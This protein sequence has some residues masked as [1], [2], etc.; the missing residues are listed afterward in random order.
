[1]KSK[2]T[3]KPERE[4]EDDDVD[5]ESGGPSIASAKKSKITIIAASSVL[6]TVVLYF[7]FFKGDAKK[8]ELVEV[9]PPKPAAISQSED[10]KS[11]FE[12]DVKEK[13][14]EDR[15]VVAKPLVPEVP[16]LPEL[17]QGSVSQDLL[18]LPPEEIPAAIPAAPIAITDPSNPATLPQNQKPAEQ[19]LPA[20]P[21]VAEPP[22]EIDPRYAPI[23]VFGGSAQGTPARGVGYENNIVNLNQ[24]PISALPETQPG[25]SATYIKDRAH[26]I[27]QG[28]LLTAVLE[29]AINTEL[30]GSVRAIVS[31]DV[32]GEAGNDV[33]IPRG[34]RLYGAYSSKVVQGQGRV[35]IAWSRLIRPDGVDLAIRFNA[36]DQFGRSGIG[37]DIDN[38]YGSIIASSMLTSIL[39]VGGVAA[40]QKLLTNNANTTTTTNPTQGTTTTTGSATNQAIYD[41]SKTI[42]DTVSQVIG[43]TINVAPVIRV[44]QGTR[45]TVIVNADIVVP[46]QKNH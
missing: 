21:A 4:I 8:E 6:I 18:P 19:I 30:P 22:K 29:T 17:P 1:M 13:S 33:L 37:G 24:D 39:A 42:V 2:F 15:D 46:S 25:V 12:I 7:L 10:G 28:K 9:A 11:P 3:K 35:E 45:I 20:A 26:T 14:Q 44:P 34:S 31:R 5:I 40:A 32:Y 41:V 23:I 16:T 38:K 27:A 43:N 36:S